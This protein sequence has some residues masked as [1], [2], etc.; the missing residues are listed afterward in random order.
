MLQI[1]NTTLPTPK[2]VIYSQNK[3][4]SA[5]TG[6]LDSGYFVGDLIGIKKKYEVTF[7]ALT[8]AQLSTVRAA[9]NTDFATVTITNAEGGTDTVTA[10]FGDL[11][12]ES[13]SWRQG[14]QYAMNAT[15][16]IIER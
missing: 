11:T 13:Y 10:Y 5:N 3:L 9:I 4:W 14:I 16:S 6:R 15:V 7:P 8:T 12:V 2:T 1:D